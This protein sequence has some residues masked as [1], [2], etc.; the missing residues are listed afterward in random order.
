MYKRQ[1]IDTA[2]LK[3][4]V[5]YCFFSGV[6]TG[7][8]VSTAPTTLSPVSASTTVAVTPPLW[9]NAAAA[10]SVSRVVSRCPLYTSVEKWYQAPMIPDTLSTNGYSDTKGY[11]HRFNARLEWKIS[12]NQ[13]LVIVRPFLPSLAR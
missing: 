7:V 12:E 9:A 11:N 4:E 2:P 5:K 13:N 1:G 3:A 8:S 10:K 6:F